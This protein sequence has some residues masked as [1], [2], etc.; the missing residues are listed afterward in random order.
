M[1]LLTVVNRAARNSKEWS[2]IP[3]R[4]QTRWII[5]EKEYMHTQSSS[6]T[7]LVVWIKYYIARAVHGRLWMCAVRECAS[8]LMCFVVGKG[9]FHMVP[10]RRRITLHC[11]V[12]VE[13]V[14]FSKS[15]QF[16]R[17]QFAAVDDNV[18]TEG[19]VEAFILMM[20]LWT[21]KCR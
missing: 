16:K 9:D 20:H 7:V 1:S 8:I 5:L 18:A 19:I 15:S 10:N 11:C 3:C 6:A 21:L 12:Q 17:P 13:F 4:R 2:E 14:E